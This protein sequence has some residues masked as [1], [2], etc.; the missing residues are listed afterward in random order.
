MNKKTKKSLIKTALQ[1]L[2]LQVSGNILFIGT[3][4]GYLY[5]DKVLHQPSLAA[6][7]VAS[8]FAHILFFLLSRDWVFSEKT[9]RRKSLDELLRFIVFMGLNFFINL[10]IIAGL[11]VYAGISPYIGQFVA[12]LF[13]SVW[14]YLGLKFWVFRHIRHV[15]HAAITI[16]TKRKHAKRRIAYKQL[17]T[18]QKAKGTA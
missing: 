3:Y 8:I 11:E 2:K 15:R 18:K 5:S 6:L 4:L 13:F 16:E 7:A 14:T 12:G 1:Y 9:G 17:Q 10:G